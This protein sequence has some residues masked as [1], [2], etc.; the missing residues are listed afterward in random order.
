MQV[1]Q[2]KTDRLNGAIQRERLGDTAVRLI[3]VS[4][5]TRPAAACLEDI[6]RNNGFGVEWPVA[7]WPDAPAVVA[8]LDGGEDRPHLAFDC[9]TSTVWHAQSLSDV[10]GGTSILPA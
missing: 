3:N 6:L 10:C 4:S 8:R 1:T 2:E 5:P 7:G 9:A